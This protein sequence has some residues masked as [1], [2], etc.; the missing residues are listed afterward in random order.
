MGKKKELKRF[1][2]SKPFNPSDIKGLSEDE[3]NL[4]ASDIRENIIDN[5]AKNGGHIAS[6]L[7][8]V[9]LTVAIH[10]FFN[11][12][13]DKLIF[14]VGHQ[15]YAHKILSGRSLENLR[16]AN[17]VSGFQKRNES[18]FDPYEAGHSS[19]SI[20]AAMGFAVSR[21]LNKEDYNI[22]AVIGDASLANG[23]AYEALN[24]LGTFNHKVILIINDNEQSIGK[25]VGYSSN[26]WERFRLSKGYLKRKARYVRIMKKTAFGR[27]IYKV[28]SAIKNFFKYLVVRKNTFQNMG[29][30]YISNIDGHDIKSLERAFKYAVN[31]PSSVA[32]HVTTIKGKGYEYAEKDNEGE[33]HG[34]TPFNKETGESLT[35]L[36]DNHISWSEVYANNLMDIMKN[37][38]Q[39]VVVSPATIVGSKLGD[40]YKEF[41]DRTF[42]VGIAEEHAAI[43]ASGMATSNLHPYVS[44]YSTFLQRSY[45]EISHDVARMNVPVTMLIDRV[46]LPGEDGE[47]H[48]GIFDVA[49]LMSMPN[50]AICMA[51]DMNE[52]KQLMD[53]SVNYPYPLAIRY[54]R[55]N[56]LKQDSNA[57]RSL[58]LGQWRLEN[59][60]SG[61]AIISYGPV[62]NELKERYK[63]YDVVNAIFQKPIDINLLKSLLDK[64]IVIYDLYGTKE[65]FAS[66]VIDTLND[67]GYKKQVK[68][69]CVPNDFISHDK[70]INQRNKLHL[71]LDSLDALIGK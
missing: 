34:V 52:A 68:C 14:D 2:L 30:Y 65:G 25:S 9:E 58:S 17:G 29:L 33:W 20:S 1:D 38:P 19:T 42:D 23:V 15:S 28:T 67:L 22:I 62:I 18:E 32:I 51:K 36:D 8:V 48:E 13:K 69:L 27:G 60:G 50:V 43:F 61:A 59:V 56:T 53:F 26:T 64:D 16:Q 57:P 24:H 45:D 3:L 66:L 44:M 11:L 47:T 37:N 40:I 54:P 70:I 5:C 55:G 46:G 35:K 39:A 6:S 31:A 4:L 63:G 49:Y 71:D 21:D 41:P 12:P 7:G 10:H